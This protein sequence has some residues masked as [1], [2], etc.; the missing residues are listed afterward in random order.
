[1]S[2]G[3]IS[4]P[5]LKANLLRDGVDLAFETDLLYLDVNHMR[6]GVNTDTPTHDLQVNGTTRTVYLETDNLNVGNI[7]VS[8]NTIDSS[9][10][11]LNLTGFNGTAV[12][13]QNKLKIDAVTLDANTIST[14]TA[15]TNLELRPTGTVE[16]FSDTTVHGNLHATGSITADG[17]I[18][19]GDTNTDNIVFNADI[20]SNIIPN[21]DNTFTLGNTDKRW[22]DIWVNTI[23]SDA[24]AT[25]NL[26]VD[27]IQL[28]LRQ[29]KIYYVATNGTDTNSGTHQNDPFASLKKAITVA[30]NGDTIFLYPGTYTEIFPLTVPVGVTIKGKSLRSVTIQPTAGTIDK[31]VFLLNGETTVEDITITGYRYNSTNNT[32]YAFRFANNFTVTTRSPYVRNVTVI[33]R[34]SVTSAGDPYGFDSNDAGKGILLDGSVANIASKEAACLFHS[35]TFF[36]PNQECLSATNGTR[37][38]WL[39]SFSYFAD[40]GMYLYS[41][42]TGFANAGKTAIRLSGG[43]GT[44]NVGNTISYYDTDGVTVLA[45]GTIANKDTDGKLYLTGKVN[46]LVTAHD[47]GGKAITAFGNAKLSTAQKKWGSASLVLD[48]TT[49][50]AFVQSNTDFAFGTDAWCIEAWV[51]NTGGQSAVQVIF[52]FRTTTNQVVPYLNIQV[53]GSLLYYVNG[54]SA[55]TGGT[56]PLNT[57]THIA[58]AKNGTT[59]KMFINGTQS[60]STYT[61]NNTYVQGPLTIGARFDS[62]LAFTGYIDDVRISKGVAR[63]TS[64]FTAPTGILANDVYTVLLS[65]FDGTNNSTTFLDETILIQDVRNISNGATATKIDLV[66]YSDFGVEVRAIGSATVY[67]NYG[68]YGTGLGVVAYLIGHNLAYIGTGKR[69]DNDVTYVVQDNEI[70]EASGAKIYYSSVDH[71]GDFRIGDLFYVNQQAGTVQFTTSSFNIQSDTGVTF[72]NGANT[73]YIDGVKIE[74]GNL[75]LTGNT[76]SSTT[77]PINI[78]SANDQI[79]FT[80]NVNITGNLDVVGNVTIG[81]N[82]QVGDQTTDTVSFVAGIDS[83]LL[84]NTTNTYDLGSNSLRWKY[85]YTNE[86][87]VGNINISNNTITTSLPNTDLVLEANSSG[88]I[89]IPSND[90]VITRDLTVNSTSTLSNTT[91][92]GTIAHTGNYTQ[93]GD[94]TQTGV[95]NITGTLTT[96]GYAQFENIK[97]DGNTIST[98]ESGTDL[99]LDAIVQVGNFEVRGNLITNIIADSI[100]EISNTGAGYFKISGT[101]GFVIPVGDE[102]D[103]PVVVEAGMIRYNTT[104]GRVEVYTGTYWS[105]IAGTVGGVTAAEAENIGITSAIILG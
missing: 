69:S 14:N 41:G 19:I 91:V 53:G 20:N 48:G 89:S 54:V 11:I 64:N 60:G 15:S 12:V 75:R 87:N 74:T 68:V 88:I 62:T 40:K 72:T 10:G 96:T 51:Y 86:I 37:V 43:S 45:S 35:V 25:D 24:I 2:I 4:G 9:T 38:E 100:T 95:T 105:G 5:L 32:G 21:T 104:D 59:T 73:T 8:G 1:M 66:D 65:R 63:Y 94:Y 83:D 42:A 58:L 52:D 77:G 39:N 47:R 55:I 80:N 84:P 29:G 13:Y 44:F 102:N 22:A 76:F 85:L 92:V 36:T 17:N 49:D 82:I 70:T 93:T 18:T 34:G 97:I 30:A 27:G 26:T 81:G 61:D 33:S 31:D 90:V 98:T 16:V 56:I 7:T 101:G 3:R 79:N 71:K 6:I 67:G 46:G 57:W 50:Y 99:V 28:T 23:H 103:R 78:T